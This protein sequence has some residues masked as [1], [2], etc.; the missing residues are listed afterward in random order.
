MNI[1]KIESKLI[2]TIFFFLLILLINGRSLLGFYILGFRVGELLTGVA[3]LFAFFIFPTFSYFKNEYS[4]KVVLSFYLL[5]AYFVLQN[6]FYKEN[7]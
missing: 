6:Y 7:F 3:L 4:F 1:V 2:N 5:I